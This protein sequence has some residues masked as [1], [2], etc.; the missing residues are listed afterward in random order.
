M[1]TYQFLL[2]C[3]RPLIPLFGNG[4]TTW[5]GRTPAFILRA[6]GGSTSSMTVRSRC[7]ECGRRR[8]G[9]WR[10]RI[11]RVGIWRR[12]IGHG[13]RIWIRWG[14]DSGSG[15][16]WR[17]RVRWVGI[18]WV[19]IRRRSTYESAGSW[20]KQRSGLRGW[21]SL[22]AAMERRVVELL[23]GSIGTRRIGSRTLGV[24]VEQ[25]EV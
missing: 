23:L 25:V 13:S 21:S 18:R 5:C 14:S 7:R 4:W 12:S 8:V 16:S 2:V 10:V 1:R 24:G 17:I 19:R 3:G 20:R 15:G 11:W 6:S 9:V 22:R